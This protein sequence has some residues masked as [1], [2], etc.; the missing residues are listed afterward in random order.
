ML[1][2][3]VLP[4]F[5]LFEYAFFFYEKMFYKMSLKSVKKPKGYTEG[6]GLF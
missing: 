6:F 3:I 4:Y 2:C 1:F 5:K